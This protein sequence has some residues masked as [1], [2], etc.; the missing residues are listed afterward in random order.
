MV[1]FVMALIVSVHLGIYN[2]KQCKLDGVALFVTDPFC[3]NSCPLHNFPLFKPQL[4]IATFFETVMQLKF[5]VK[6]FLVIMENNI[7]SKFHF[8]SFNQLCMVTF[9]RF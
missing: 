1:D 6:I 3:V 4:N 5:F 2:L 8:P 9:L 7:L